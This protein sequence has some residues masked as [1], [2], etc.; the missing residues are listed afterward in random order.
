MKHSKLTMVVSLC[1][2]IACAPDEGQVPEFSVVEASIPELQELMETGRLTSRELVT[3]HLVRIALY[4]DR[5]NA[6]ISINEEALAEAD[7]LDAERAVFVP[8]GEGGAAFADLAGRLA[9]LVGSGGSVAWTSGE[10]KR[11]Q[12]LFAEHGVELAPP[13][14]DAEIAG[15]LLDPAGA[16]TL[17]A[18]ASQA[19]AVKLRTWEELAGRGAKAKPAR[20]RPR[21]N[22]RSREGP[23]A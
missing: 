23:G 2:V 6:A 7:A 1:T 12:T 19:L 10:S 15:L 20:D 5:L 9:P 17:A 11:L 21:A 16:R 18:I 8:L 3:A 14:F 22:K 13:H 4:E